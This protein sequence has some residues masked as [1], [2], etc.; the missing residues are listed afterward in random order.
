LNVILNQSW[1]GDIAVQAS[2]ANI[3]MGYTYNNNVIV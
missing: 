2:T 1:E 3:G